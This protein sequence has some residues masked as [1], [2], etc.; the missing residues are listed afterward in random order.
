MSSWTDS[1][2]QYDMIDNVNKVF[3]TKY[4]LEKYV[5]MLPKVKLQF[6]RLRHP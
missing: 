5:R 2:F 3:Q 4:I 6:L 1:P